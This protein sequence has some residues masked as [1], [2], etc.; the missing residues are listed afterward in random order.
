MTVRR[1]SGRV[2]RATVVVSYRPGYFTEPVRAWRQLQFDS[3][4]VEERVREYLYNAAN[5]RRGREVALL[6]GAGWGSG[7]MALPGTPKT[8]APGWMR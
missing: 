2:A 6:T 3:A 4:A 1:T 5:A 8:L 7:T